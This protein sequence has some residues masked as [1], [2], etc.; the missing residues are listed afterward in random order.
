MSGH[1]KW[2]NIKVRKMAVDAARGKIYTKHAR[3][4]EIA[5]REGGGKDPATNPRLRGALENAKADSVPNTILERAVKK[6]AG[7]GKEGAHMEELLYEA[8][9][10]AGTAYLIECLTDNR[11]RTLS[12]VKNILHN[13]GGRMAEQG[14]VSWMFE[15]KGVVVANVAGKNLEEIELLMIDAGAEDIEVENEFIHATTAGTTWGKVRDALKAAGCSIEEA[16]LKFV[17]KEFIEIS[18]A[19]TQQRISELLSALEEDDDV[20]IVHTN[21]R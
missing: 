4:I 6:G 14:S 11:N 13:H 19:Q 9:G 21:A 18:D 12:N 8:Y 10:P 5:V 20:S 7:E 3:L 16:G 1:S 2:H 15:K 17:P